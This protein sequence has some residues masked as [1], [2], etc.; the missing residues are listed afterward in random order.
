MQFW[1]CQ[2]V[3]GFCREVTSRPGPA[4]MR[5]Y[6]ARPELLLELRKLGRGFGVRLSWVGGADQLG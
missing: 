3:R 5:R 6:R 1:G 4:K 2:V